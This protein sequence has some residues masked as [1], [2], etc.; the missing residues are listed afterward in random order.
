MVEGLTHLY[1]ASNRIKYLN[2]SLLSETLV[3]RIFTIYLEYYNV[4][5][6]SFLEHH[7]HNVLATKY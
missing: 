1:A 5:K 4:Q 2:A 7:L 3:V 6:I